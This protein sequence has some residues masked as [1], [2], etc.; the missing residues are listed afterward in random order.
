MKRFFKGFRK[1]SDLRERTENQ[2]LK[3]AVLGKLHDIVGHVLT[4]QDEQDFALL[5]RAWKPDLSDAEVE[6]YIRLLRSAASGE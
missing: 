5:V 3:D 1:A 2:K 6:E 4:S